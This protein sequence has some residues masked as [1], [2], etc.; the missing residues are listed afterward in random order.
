VT[1]CD[2]TRRLIGPYVDGELVGDERRVV[3]GHLA[4]CADC[5]T[6]FAREAA[7][8]SAVEGAA[9]RAPAPEELRERVARLL[10]QPPPARFWRAAAVAAGLAAGVALVV[11]WPGRGAGPR[12]PAASPAPAPA[13]AELVGVAV[14]SHLRYARGQ[15]PLEVRSERPEEVSGW[16]SGRVP[17]H[18]ALPDYPVGPGEQKFYH[19]EGG[20]LV[21][22]QGDYAA[23]VAYRM[24]GRPIS[25]LVTSAARVTPS[26]SR[27]VQ[28][29]GLTFYLESVAGL[30]VITWSDKG[31]TYALA[32]DLA[33][34]GER[35]CLVCHGSPEERSKIEGFSRRP[36]V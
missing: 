8:S 12:P 29:G 10:A 26:G 22:L 13:V 1:P 5:R 7:L 27:T 34:S 25:L 19:L 16:F 30:N 28:S 24:E 3:D 2:A 32:S 21:A 4:R 36:S 35:S 11:F 33:V 20:R 15:L 31:L 17:F 18:V 6:L 23:Y 9:L 14:D